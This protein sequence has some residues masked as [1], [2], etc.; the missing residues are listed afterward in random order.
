M[1]SP[2]SIWNQRLTPR[3]KERITIDQI[4]A[5]DDDLANVRQYLQENG[6][7]TTSLDRGLHKASVIVVSGMDSNVFGDQEITAEIAVIEATGLTAEEVL[8]EVERVM[9][10]KH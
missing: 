2:D 3:T 7:E 9:Q 1:C 10:F 6:Y 8:E 5:V 4:I